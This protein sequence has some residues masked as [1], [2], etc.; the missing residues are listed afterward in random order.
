MMFSGPAAAGVIGLEKPHF[1]LFGDTVN[2]T[3]RLCATSDFFRIQISS[4]FKEAIQPAGCF[5]SSERG[6]IYIKGKGW[7]N[8]FWLI[9]SRHPFRTV[10]KFL[11]HYT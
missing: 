5:E 1:C 4:D 8:T 11:A 2:M 9:R 7:H 3:S 6:V 10:K